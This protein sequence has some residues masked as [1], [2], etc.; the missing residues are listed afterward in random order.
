MHWLPHW[1]ARLLAKVSGLTL[2]GLNAN[3]AMASSKS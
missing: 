1:R 3:L 2:L